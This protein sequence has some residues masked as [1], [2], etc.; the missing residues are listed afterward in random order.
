MA[1]K[2]KTIAEI[3]AMVN[4][5][6]AYINPKRY[7]IPAMD[8]V[9]QFILNNATRPFFIIGDYDAD[10][11][12]S[13]AELYFL[14]TTFGITPEWYDPHRF[15]DGYG[16]NPQIIKMV[17]ENA[18]LILVDN[19]IVAFDAVE[20][21]K[22]K[23]CL[24]IILDH[25]LG[26]EDG[27]LPDADFIVDPNAID[28]QCEFTAYCGAGLVFKLAEVAFKG[29][30]DDP[31]FLQI[32]NLAAFGT[33]GDC[34]DLIGENWLIVKEHIH[35]TMYNIGLVALCELFNI[36]EADEGDAGF[37]ICPALNAPGR[38]LD[39][40]ATLSVSLLLEQ[41]FNIAREKAKQ[42]KALNEE[43]KRLVEVGVE[44]A[45]DCKIL[46]D[47]LAVFAVSNIPEGIVGIVAGRMAEKYKVPAFCFAY[48]DENTLK[49]SA[50]T[51]GENH[52]KN[53]LDGVSDCLIKYGGHKSAAGLSLRA[54]KL[55]D[56]IDGVS[57]QCTKS[58]GDD[59]TGVPVKATDAAKIYEV[60]REA[61]PF[62]Q[63]NPQFVFEVTEYLVP[64]N[65]T[66]KLYREMGKY[67]KLFG[68]NLDVLCFDVI[69]DEHEI[70]EKVEITG[71]ISENVFLGKTTTQIET[72]KYNFIN[73]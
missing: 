19:G 37:K 35:D 28:G 33:V 42:L 45:E 56:F 6:L 1:K 22:A 53:I 44:R 5:R 67:K 30:E 18:V 39:D 68:K 26:S 27:R 12:F 16:A 32:A 73:N 60:I 40:G 52:L 65:K 34:V 46:R 49:G 14:L 25:H 64:D 2:T 41:D 7:V 13:T 8:A 36:K 17:P 21:A 66:K 71:Y 23:G 38:L 50:R 57:A 43:R 20:A 15:T 9:W 69:P 4:E 62:G 72:L 31:M 63:A 55:D 54:D 10:G 3:K 11:V 61:A 51:Y 58:I 47:N 29:K 70:T 59:V 48:K 24:V